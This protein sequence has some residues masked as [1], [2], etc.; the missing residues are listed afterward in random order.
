MIGIPYAYA[1]VNGDAICPVCGARIAE[2]HDA[3]GEA[4]STNYAA[5]Y[6][7]EHD[8]EPGRLTIAAMAAIAEGRGR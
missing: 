5:H 7:A 4:T 8:G 1:C 3:T 2:T 6:A